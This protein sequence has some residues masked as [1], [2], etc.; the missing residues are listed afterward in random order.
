M[1]ARCDVCGTTVNAVRK[2]AKSD[3]FKISYDDFEHPRGWVGLVG[4]NSAYRNAYC[5][6]KECVVKELEQT[7]G[8]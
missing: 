7:G 1:M 4:T 5:C 6:S 8:G 2:V 3:P